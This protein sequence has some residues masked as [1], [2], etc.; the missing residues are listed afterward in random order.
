MA[1]I[2]RR[3]EWHVYFERLTRAVVESRAETQVA[4]LPRGLQTDAPWVAL[5]GVRYDTQHDLIEIG[6]ELADKTTEDYVINGPREI[7]LDERKNGLAGLEVIDCHG[8][9][10]RVTLRE[11]VGCMS[12]E[13]G[14]QKEEG[15]RRKGG[16]VSSLKA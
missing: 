8:A 15:R 6:F 4:D 11:P 5:V 9:S 3:R 13:G 14:K 16:R 7:S 1:M 2:L 12:D 10:H